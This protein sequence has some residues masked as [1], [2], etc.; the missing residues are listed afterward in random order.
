M[1]K[2]TK[3]ILIVSGIS[4]VLGSI[5]CTISLFSINFDLTK[6]S[7][8]GATYVDH[9]LSVSDNISIANDISPYL[10]IGE[11][12][13]DKVHI[14]Y[15][16]NH[17]FKYEIKQN[18]EKLLLEQVILN[19]KDR[20]MSFFEKL[21]FGIFS[22]GLGVVVLIPSQFRGTLT[23][24]ISSATIRF[25]NISI[26]NMDLKIHATAG[27]LRFENISVDNIDLQASTAIARFDNLSANSIDILTSAAISTFNN[28]SA[29]SIA[30]ES[31]SGKIEFSN[32]DA[33]NIDLNLNGGS[34]SGTILGNKNDFTV[35]NTSQ[36]HLKNIPL[37]EG[38]GSKT[39]NLAISSGGDAKIS[40][41]E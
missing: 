30:L 15:Y 32:L 35:I 1:K 37:S 6:L 31:S 24:N 18:S 19:N 20:Q 33:Q 39:L 8:M 29:K 13:D 38:Q 2:T 17:R 26:D 11:S 21:Q 12:P 9:K 4:F 40:F 7:G 3:N 10:C 28:L 25:E 14:S 27:I 16:D 22:W 5:I 36:K 41:T 23:A 34:L